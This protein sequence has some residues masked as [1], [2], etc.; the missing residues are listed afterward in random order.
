MDFK[1]G[2]TSSISQSITAIPKPDIDAMRDAMLQQQAEEIKRLRSALSDMCWQ[3][4]YRGHRGNKETLWTGGLSALEHAFS[5][6]GWDD[7]VLCDEALKK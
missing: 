4:A 5:V 7:P 1:P 2:N 3:F 6:L